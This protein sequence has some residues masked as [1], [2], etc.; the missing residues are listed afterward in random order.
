MVKDKTYTFLKA[1]EESIDR[2]ESKIEAAKLDVQYAK[3]SVD[4]GENLCRQ[5]EVNLREARKTLRDY[6]DNDL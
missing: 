4:N 6:I 1:Y 5:M 2:L 3:E